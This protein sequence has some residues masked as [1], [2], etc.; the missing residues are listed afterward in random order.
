MVAAATCMGS[1]PCTPPRAPTAPPP[2]PLRPRAVVGN[3]P[4]VPAEK[5]EK[6]L[7]VIKKIYSQIGTVREGGALARARVVENGRSG[8]QHHCAPA[9]RWYAHAG[10][11]GDQD[12]QG[13]RVHRVRDAAGEA[14]RWLRVAH[15]AARVCAP[16][17]SPAPRGGVQEAKAAREQTNGYK[18][19]KNHVFAVNMFDDFDKYAKVPEEYQ[20][21]DAKAFQSAVSGRWWGTHAHGGAWTSRRR[22]VSPLPPH[23]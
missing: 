3:I 19:D 7:S 4:V 10:G 17:C 9:R 20:A 12:E 15:T 11:R 5:Y 8:R 23:A 2:P 1:M 13:V 21:P 18:L 6:L 22:S 14:A 16:A